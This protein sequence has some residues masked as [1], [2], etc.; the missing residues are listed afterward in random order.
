M[1]WQC[2]NSHGNSSY[3]GRVQPGPS[4]CQSTDPGQGSASETH[5]SNADCCSEHDWM[6]DR[7][8]AYSSIKMQFMNL[9]PL[10]CF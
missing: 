9:Q 8:I 1:T 4:S 10:T 2:A 3:Q 6:R 5:A 7:A